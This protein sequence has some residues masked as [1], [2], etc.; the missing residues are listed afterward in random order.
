MLTR[1]RIAELLGNPGSIWIKSGVYVNDAAALMMDDKQN[2]K[3]TKER[4]R[5]KKKS[6]A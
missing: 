2:I 5:Y 1:K 4:R 6:V 3:V